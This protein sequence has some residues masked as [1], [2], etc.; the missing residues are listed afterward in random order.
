MKTLLIIPFLA[1]TLFSFG[2]TD[3]I[4]LRSRN[5]ALHKYKKST[6]RTVYDHASSNFGMAPTIEVKTAVLDS[7]KAIS[8]TVAVMYTS[9]YCSQRNRYEEYY[10]LDLVLD[11]NGQNRNVNSPT[12]VRPNP[13]VGS[14]WRPGV[15]TVVHHPLFSQTHSLDSV[16]RVLD[17]EYYFNLPSDSIRFIGFDNNQAIQN[18]DAVTPVKHKRE[19]KNSFGWEL[20]FMI[21]SPILFFVG[22]SKFVWPSSSPN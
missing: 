8:D 6:E 3:I 19:K 15:D 20:L 9:R 7:V 13:R 22:M 21:L 4:E 11:T 14:L 16:K 5:A 2:Q 18:E 17:E 1:V 10:Q 12:R